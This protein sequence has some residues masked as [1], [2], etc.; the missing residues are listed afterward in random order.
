MQNGGF[1]RKGLAPGESSPHLGPR[2]G[3]VPAQR[4][5][6]AEAELQRKREAFLAAERGQQL[7]RASTH[8]DAFGPIRQKRSLGIA[9]LLWF[10]LGQFSAHRFYLV[11]PSAA[12]PQLGLF[13]GAL[14][15]MLSGTVA[16][17]AGVVMLVIWCGWIFVDLFL[18]PGLHR[19]NCVQGDRY[20]EMRAAYS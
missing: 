4:L 7:G 3:I 12:L 19:K 14:I 15:L 20:E 9:Y 17:V 18:M 8:S 2:P 1:G 10:L 6:P 11:G 13:I 5:D 16:A